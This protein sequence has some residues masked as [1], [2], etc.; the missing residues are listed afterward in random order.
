[1]PQTPP[2]AAAL[3]SLDPTEAKALLT[4]DKLGRFAAYQKTISSLTGDGM[5]MGMQARTKTGMQGAASADDRS[6]K[7]AAARKSALDK[8]G[9]TQDE[10]GKLTQLLTPYYARVRAMERLF[11]KTAATKGEQSQP[12]PPAGS[13]EA[14]RLKAQDDQR[15]QLEAMR[16]E[17]AMQYG[18]KALE[19]VKKH[20]PELASLDHQ[21]A[22]AAMGAMAP[23]N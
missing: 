21:T 1:M 22:G 8:S 2:A 19:L 14:A 6:A 3:P 13:M 17:F 5:G 9:L 10:I 15:A 18:A 12:A 16:R 11:G 7:L 23:K 4:E 20:E